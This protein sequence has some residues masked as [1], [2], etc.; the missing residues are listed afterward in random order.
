MSRSIHAA[1]RRACA[2]AAAVLAVSARPLAAETLAVTRL[3]S[4]VV[5]AHGS[6]EI[7]LTFAA[8]AVAGWYRPADGGPQ[9]TLEGRS[10]DGRLE[11][12]AI[13]QTGRTEAL[14]SCLAPRGGTLR[15]VWQ[16]AGRRLAFGAD[17][18]ANDL[19]AAQLINGHYVRRDAGSGGAI[20]LLLLDDGRVKVQAYSL[21]AGAGGAA[22]AGDVAGYAELQG[23]ILQVAAD[24]GCL[25]LIEPVEGGLAVRQEGRCRAVFSGSYLRRS[26][27][28]PDWETFRWVTE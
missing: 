19:P 15:G 23:E 8:G 5:G 17:E 6:V 18:V 4:G 1:L 9:K 2:L 11:L 26:A 20:D 7:S 13:D 10:Q 16:E 27:V 24:D 21:W 25:L 28:V 14:V 22:L 12:R 3:Y